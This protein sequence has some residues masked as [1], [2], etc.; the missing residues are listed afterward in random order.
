MTNIALLFLTYDEIIHKKTLE[1]TRHYTTYIN[2]KTPNQVLEYKHCHLYNYPTEWGSISMVNATVKILEDVYKNN[3]EYV[4]I[5]SHDAYPLV[6]YQKFNAFFKYQKKSCFHLLKQEE[7]EWKTSQWWILNRNDMNMIIKYHDEYSQIK[8]RFK[9]QAAYDEL[10]F[11][12]L[13]KYYNPVYS[14]YEM[15]TVYIE[16]LKSPIQ[17]HPTTFNRITDIDHIKQSFFIRKTLPTFTLDKFIPKKELVIKIIGT[18]TPK[19]NGITPD[20]DLIL[21]TM[22]DTDKIQQI[23]KDHCIR[24]H[25]TL[26]CRITN[27]IQDVIDLCAPY[28]ETI[29]IND[30][31]GKVLSIPSFSNEK[32]SIYDTNKIFQKN[33]EYYLY[34][35]PKI[36]FLFLTIGDINQPEVWTEYFHNN[37]HKVN[38]YVHPKHPSLVKTKWLKSNIIESLVPT[39]WGFITAAYYELLKEALKNKDNMKF[40]FISESCIP[41]KTFDI[42]YHKLMMDHTNTSYIKFMEIDKYNM[43]VRIKSQPKYKELEPFVKHYARM[44]LSRYHSEKLIACKEFDFFNKMHVG[45]EFFLTCIH[46]VKNKDYI[47]D[48]EITYDNWDAINELRSTYNSEIELLYEKLEGNVSDKETQELKRKLKNKQL[49]RDDISKNPK[50]YTTMTPNEIEIAI[51]QEGFF[52]RKFTTKKLPW[53]YSILNFI[54]SSNKVVH[55][56]SKKLNFK[57]MVNALF[58]HIPKTAGM[59][60]YENVLELDRS[61]GWFLGDPTKKG[62]DVAINKMNTSG[63]VM[64]GHISYKSAL[65]EKILNEDFFKHSFK[66]CFVRNP[67][68]RLVS[69][70][71]YHRVKDRL[72]LVFDDFVELLYQEYMDKKIPPIGLY[73]I[74]SFDKK[75]KL[76]HNQ[77]YGNQYNQMIDWIPC[78]IGYIGRIENFDQDMNHI[79]RVLGYNGPEYISPKINTTKE[80]DYTQYFV[81]KKTKEY[82]S[83]MYKDDIQRFGYKL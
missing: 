55:N 59:S 45:D 15:K 48:F 71:K 30:E 32:V 12:S 51:K 75:S 42:F 25:W 14:Y 40:V 50:T 82:A 61:F 8:K 21:I 19:I 53:T 37:W 68:A 7:D 22:I 29:Y 52:W 66:F 16:W 44:C 47:K 27:T 79:L 73:N 36:A 18:D 10:Y 57:P 41:L 77:I 17:K 23:Y 26:W 64:L 13:L 28:W 34:S 67:Y 63:G 62:D 54:P 39:E 33:K 65:N 3:H 70:Y 76:Y 56:T 24:I 78:D 49:L 35:P 81:N 1:W 43:N 6:S 72:N 83:K 46:P 9:I 11:L 20:V 5:L 58:I 31:K 2:A 74:K 80:D 60:I 38:I 69:L 4:M